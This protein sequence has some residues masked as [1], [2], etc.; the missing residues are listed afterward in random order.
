MKKIFTAIV[1]STVMVCFLAFNSHAEETYRWKIGHVRSSGSAIDTDTHWFTDTISQHTGGRI[2]FEIYPQSKL[3]DYSIVQE[4]CSFG[5]VEM[6]I[7]PFGTSV[8][9]KCAL[10]F[11]PCLVKNWEE[12]RQVY[13]YD[14]ILM[15]RMRELLEKQNIK[16][17]GG[18]PVYFGGIVLTEK[19][20][21]PADPTVTKKM[22]IRIPPIHSFKLTARALGYT[23]YPIT[24][25]YA[26]EGLKTGMVAGMIGGGAE[27]YAGLGELAQYYLPVRDHFE[28]WFVYMN[29]DLWRQLSDAEQTVLLTTAREMEERRYAVAEKEEETSLQKLSD[30]GT[31]IISFSDDQMV[32]IRKHVRQKVWPIMKEEIGDAFD[33][34]VSSVPTQ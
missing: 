34:V 23:P 24:W 17:L 12:A 13:S 6:F 8:D 29:L 20:R 7:G 26:R 31:T 28:Y 2:T 16:I 14:S 27:G 33:E 22:I 21:D 25:F 11:T 4:R 19:P 15:K 32:K 1:I 18:W 30:Q 3:G 5:E 10:A 9:K